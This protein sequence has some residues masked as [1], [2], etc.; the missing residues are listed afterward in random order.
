MRT[1]TMILA[2]V[3][4]A[5]LAAC[6]TAGGGKTAASKP[7]TAPAEAFTAGSCGGLTASD[8]AAILHVPPTAVKGPRI[9]KA[10]DLDEGANNC[11]YRDSKNFFKSVSFY[12]SVQ[13]S[14][15]AAT[16]S[17][18]VEKQNFASLASVAAE[19]NLGDEAWRYTWRGPGPAP[20]LLM[21][22]G[23]VWL[24]VVQPEDEPSQLKIAQI[25]LKH[26]T[27]AH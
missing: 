3:L 24:D 8:A 7:A 4:T 26:I 1:S 25:V 10:P 15:A 23:N 17:M 13:N 27:K 19:N 18:N 2:A 22:K 12:L 6:Q 5:A 14:A 9:T 16:S 11:S 21:R 20:R